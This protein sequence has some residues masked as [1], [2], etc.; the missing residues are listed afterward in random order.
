[1]NAIAALPTLAVAPSAR[2]TCKSAA[3]AHAVRTDHPEA[4][5]SRRE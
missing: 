1:M 2:V 4:E 5:P 3:K